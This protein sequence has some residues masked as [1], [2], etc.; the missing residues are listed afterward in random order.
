MQ[1]MGRLP[2]RPRQWRLVVS[3]VS[4]EVLMAYADGAL[5]PAERIAVE[6]ALHRHPEYRQKVEKYQATGAPIQALFRETTRIDHLGHL[7]DQ[8][9]WAELAPAPA[10]LRPA[11]VRRLPQGRVVPGRRPPL[12]QSYRVAIAASVALLF[13]A[14]LGWML[15]PG[16]TL[17]VPTAG[18][19]RVSDGS[20]MAQG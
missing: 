20:L 3:V 2:R 16:S 10:T 1:S 8:I 19:I 18:M 13:G 11:E 5:D 14:A 17:S 4:D 7:I 9:R 15:Q 6:A 12:Q